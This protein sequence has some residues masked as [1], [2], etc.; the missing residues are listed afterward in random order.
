[1]EEICRALNINHFYIKNWF[2]IN[3]Y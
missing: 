1:M 3:I 2:N